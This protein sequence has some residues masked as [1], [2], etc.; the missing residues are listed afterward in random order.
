VLIDRV[1]PTGGLAV[2]AGAG[3]L[4]LVVSLSIRSQ[5]V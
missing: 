1:G 2:T 5:L 4:T 3:V